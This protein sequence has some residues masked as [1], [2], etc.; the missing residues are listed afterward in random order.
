[1]STSEQRPSRYVIGIDLGTT[2]SA[3]AY[4]DTQA[5]VRTARVLEIPQ[6]ETEGT[7]TEATMLPSFYYLPPKTEWKRGQLK[8]PLQPGEEPVDHAVGRLARLKASQVPGRVVHS[9]KSWLCHGGVDREARILPWHSDEVIGDERRSPL[10]VSA[11]YLAHLKNVWNARIAQG[12]EDALFENQD[13]TITVPASFDEVAQRLTFEAAVMAGYRRERIRLLE[14]PQ[15]AFYHWLAVQ[16]PARTATLLGAPLGEARTVLIC[17]VGGGTTDFSLFRIAP[18]KAG[19]MP[20]ILRIAVSDHLLLG[21]DNIDLSLAHRLEARLAG[22]GRRL[23]SRQWAQLVAEARRLKERALAAMGKATSSMPDEELHIAVASEG[24]S[25]MAGTMTATLSRSEIEEHILTGFVPLVGPGETTQR[26]RSVALKQLGLPYAQDSAISRHLAAFLQGR[27]ADAVLFTGGSLK[28][29]F[30]RQRLAGQIADWQ[31]RHPLVLENDAM[32]LAVALGAAHYGLVLRTQEG[33]IRGGYARS[34]YIEAARAEEQGTH[35]LIC[36]VPQGF[37]GDA[38]LRIE[39]L[40]LKALADRPARFQ[41]FSSS[42]RDRDRAGDVVALAGEDF[43][44]LPPVHARLDFAAPGKAASPRLID[45]GLEVVLQETGILQLYCVHR[46]ADGEK[47]WQLDFNVRA[48]AVSEGT[49]AADARQ[50]TSQRLSEQKVQY[51]RDK[52]DSLYGKKKKPGFE[53][54]NPKALVKDLEGLFG[55]PR[56]EWDTPFLR[57]LWPHLE[58]GLTRRGRSL[59]HEVSWLYLAGYALRPGYGFELDEWRVAELWRA[60]ELGLTFPKERQAEEQWWIMWRRV[61]GGLSREQQEKIFDRIFPALRKGEATPEVYML[62]GSLER[63]EMGQKVRLGGQLALQIAEGRKQY[64][65]QRIWALSRIAS[66]VPLYGGPEA[67]PRP[68]F[69]CEWFE[70]L[71]GLDFRGPYA[72]LNI[73]LA[74]AGRM[75]GDREFDLDEDLRTAFL[76]KMRRSGATDTQLHVVRELVPIDTATRTQLFGE[77]LPAGLVL[78]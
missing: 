53:H 26:T 46:G 5:S 13:V 12:L 8:L 30:I 10:E 51:A 47:R 71:K 11:T 16:G 9:A 39:G 73:F 44:P 42:R 70:A 19:G 25:L 36:V 3:L 48:A 65:D 4:V 32:D 18:H 69:V 76:E 60:F 2:N 61:A 50:L 45:V 52:I 68:K 38:P 40:S 22:E 17:D 35:S 54:D 1:M 67:T 56:E 62:A 49:E 31:G 24:S 6:W 28:P 33:R 72:K 74:Q 77:S 64:L 14:E 41:L 34:L 37:E 66:R 58:A 63:I 23:S 21:G 20:E 27:D 75:V 29:S 15:A 59:A 78:A 43:R 57:S 7:V 55:L